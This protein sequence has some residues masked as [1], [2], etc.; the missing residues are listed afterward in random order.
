MIDWIYFLVFLVPLVLIFIA[1]VALS[2]IKGLKDLAKAAELYSSLIDAQIKKNVNAKIKKKAL[3]TYL[4]LIYEI[5][6]PHLNATMLIETSLMERRTY[7]YY[8]FKLFK[9]L[10]DHLLLRIIL[11]KK[12]ATSLVIIPRHRKKVL[13]KVM[14]YL[15]KLHEIKI[16]PI[17]DKILFFSDDVRYGKKFLRKDLFPKLLSTSRALSYVFIDYNKPHVEISCEITEKTAKAIIPNILHIGFS[18]LE[19]IQRTKSTG[20][21]SSVLKFIRK[22]FSSSSQNFR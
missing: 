18:L 17:S 7:V 20:K 4:E 16:K 8:L 2:Y 14:N 13:S 15:S 21:E 9:S 11:D 1:P 19:G 10:P 6:I 3:R 22:A 5:E 12:P